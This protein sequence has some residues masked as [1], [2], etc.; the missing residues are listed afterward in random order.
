[1]S[2]TTAFHQL[3]RFIF[4]FQHIEAALTDL[5]V[6]MARADDET[7]R[8]LIN[9]LEYGQRVTTTDVMYARFADLGPDLAKEAKN[10]FHKIMVELTDIGKRRNDIMHSKFSLWINVDGVDGLLRQNSKLKTGKSKIFRKLDEEELLP[11][12]LDADCNRMSLLLMQLEK[13]R[14]M[15]IGWLPE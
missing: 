13:Y 7:T 14:L 15:I 2:Q 4:L 8:I 10:D 12:V 9:E 6:I 11:G 3:G 1:M 5:L